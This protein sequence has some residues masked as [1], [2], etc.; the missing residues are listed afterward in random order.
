MYNIVVMRNCMWFVGFYNSFFLW[1]RKRVD[2]LKKV[3]R[4]EL[5]VKNFIYDLIV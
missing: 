2:E 1:C 3:F 5:I 4:I